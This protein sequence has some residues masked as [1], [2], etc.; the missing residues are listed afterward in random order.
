MVRSTEP[1]KSSAQA[2][3]E[4]FDP[5]LMDISVYLEQFEI[6]CQTWNIPKEKIVLSFIASNGHDL[7][8]LLR[9]Q[10]TPE[11]V[12]DQTHE[13]IKEKLQEHYESKSNMILQRYR[14]HMLK[15]EEFHSTKTFV[16]CLEKQAVKCNFGESTEDMLRDQIEIGI[17]DE[18]TETFDCKFE[19]NPPESD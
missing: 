10:F 14:F 1:Q 15:Q 8:R 12:K 4:R 18:N 16:M 6:Y 17:Y 11:A 7:F 19:I 13:R 9:D 2:S 5:D 3:F